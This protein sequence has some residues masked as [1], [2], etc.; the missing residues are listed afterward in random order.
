MLF[1]LCARCLVNIG[2]PFH[3]KKGDLL[4]QQLAHRIKFSKKIAFQPDN[5]IYDMFYRMLDPDVNKRITM[6]QLMKRTFI[7]LF[8][9]SLIINFIHYF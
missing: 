4:Q 6:P 9:L 1:V 5:D 3:E 2:Y 8:S 7:L